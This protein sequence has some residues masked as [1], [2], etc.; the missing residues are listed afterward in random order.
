MVAMTHKALFQTLAVHQLI[1]GKH[2]PRRQPFS[3]DDL[4]DL[5]QAIL[6]AG[7]LLHPIVVRQVAIHTYEIVAGERRWRAAQIADLKE[8]ICLIVE[9][10]DQQALQA[11]II[12]NVARS[13]LNP[14]EEAQ[15]YQRLI[16]DYAYRH[17]EIAASV[18]KSRTH[19]T[20]LI[21]LLR[22]DGRVKDLVARRLLSEGHARTLIGLVP[23][24]QYALAEKCLTEQWSVRKLEMLVK[25]EHVKNLTR[26]S[27]TQVANPT[28]K[29]LETL[30]GH[31]LNSQ[32]QIESQRHGGGFLKLHFHT[33]QQLEAICGLLGVS[34]QA[35][36][37]TE[38]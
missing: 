9:F 19:V 28:F 17:D 33:V 7:G 23:A 27:K 18:G 32:V 1:P 35:V 20:N 2:Q 11:A 16:D 13:D 15:A 12:E 29:R 30:L 22:L 25:K 37:S 38:E 31:Y 36:F 21:R 10:D 24:E 14:I 8:V 26:I 4:Q 34:S 5:A 6:A 3:E